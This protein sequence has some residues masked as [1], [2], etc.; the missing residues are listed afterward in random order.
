M[1]TDFAIGYEIN[2]EALD[3]YIEQ[4]TQHVSNFE[5][6]GGYTGVNIKIYC[7]EPSD[8]IYPILTWNPD[9]PLEKPTI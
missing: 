1:N 3:T 5:R 6:S 9:A 2:R 7:D 4:N 8:Y